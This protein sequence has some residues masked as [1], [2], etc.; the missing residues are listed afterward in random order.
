MENLLKQLYEYQLLLK[1]ENFNNIIN[2]FQNSKFNDFLNFLYENNYINKKT[3]LMLLSEKYGYNYLEILEKLPSLK[4]VNI[5]FKFLKENKFLPFK[6]LENEVYIAISDP[7]KINFLGLLN[8]YF[9]GKK[10]KYFIM[11]KEDLDNI[12]TKLEEEKLFIEYINQIKKDLNKEMNTSDYKNENTESA[13]LKLVELIIKSAIKKQTSD[14]HIE[15]GEKQGKIRFRILGTMTEF[16]NLDLNVYNAVISRIKLLAKMDVSDKFKPQDGS[17]SMKFNDKSFDFRVS[18]LPTIKGESCVIRILNKSNILKKLDDI[19]ISYYNLDK[20][21]NLIS[22]P[23]GIFLVTG[24][25]G[26]GKSTTLYAVLNSLDKEKYKIITVEDPV[27]YKLEGIE[28]VQV[29]PKKGLT[30]G[31]ALRSILRQDPDIIMI[32]EIRDKETL[33]IAI[34]AALTGHLVI[35]TLHTNDSVSAINRMIDMGV[36]KY[37]IASALIGIEAQR[38][39]KITCP[40]CKKEYEPPKGLY[41]IVQPLFPKNIK[42]Y[43]GTGCEKCNYTGYISRTIISEVFIKNAEVEEMILKGNTK[44]EIEE[45]LKEK[46]DFITMFTDGIKKVINGETTIEEIF[47]AAKI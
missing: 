39:V 41:K 21:K 3:Y 18:T 14:I 19:G 20:I 45:V 12:L 17:F 35:S 29:N 11:T 47:R 2:E 23:N 33:E 8:Q 27:E 7:K 30:F 5:P 15:G 4:I 1:K 43:K 24:P 42:F 26:S 44:I 16:S 10:F 9:N 34:K 31:T 22:S 36:P 40:Y 37:L 46:H 6:I 25:T 13:V 38:L 28:Q 32:G